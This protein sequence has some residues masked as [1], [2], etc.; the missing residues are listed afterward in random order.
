MFQQ[1]GQFLENCIKT[2]QI[3]YKQ[4]EQSYNLLNKWNHHKKVFSLDKIKFSGSA[5]K[6]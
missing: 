2:S 3:R 6:L 1:I 5:G 4:C